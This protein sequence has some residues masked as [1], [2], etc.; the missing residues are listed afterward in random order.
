MAK[1]FRKGQRIIHQRR[2]CENV[3]KAYNATPAD[4]HRWFVLNGIPIMELSE[5]SRKRINRLMYQ[6]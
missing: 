6:K 3:R 1:R 2:A 5:M 4:A